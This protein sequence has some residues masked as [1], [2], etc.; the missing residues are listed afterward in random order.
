MESE[1]KARRRPLCQLAY[2][3][4][5]VG[6]W[7]GPDS[8]RQPAARGFSL[9]LTLRLY[10]LLLQDPAEHEVE[11]GAGH[12]LS[13]HGDRVRLLAGRLDGFRQLNDAGEHCFLVPVAHGRTEF[14]CVP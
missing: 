7:R 8:N 4:R 10:P 9:T 3:A 5:L 12:L 2:P 14:L 13:L 11:D 6:Q 1:V